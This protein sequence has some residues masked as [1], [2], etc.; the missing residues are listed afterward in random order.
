MRSLYSEGLIYG[1]QFAFQN[2]D[3]GLALWLKVNLMFLLCF[4]LHL[5]AIFQVQAPGGLIIIWRGNLTEGFLQ[6]RFGGLIFGGA[7][8]WRGLFLEFYGMHKWVLEM[9]I[10]GVYNYCAIEWNI[11][12]TLLFSLFQ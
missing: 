2:R 7:Y 6:Y 10:W 11:I 5:R 9:S 3:I 4:T 12:C 1:G 8:T